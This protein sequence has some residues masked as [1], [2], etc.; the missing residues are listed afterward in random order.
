[1]LICV[2]LPCESYQG[3]LTKFSDGLKTDFYC[4]ENVSCETM[5]SQISDISKEQNVLVYNVQTNPRTMFYSEVNIYADKPA[6]II[7]K[8]TT[9]YMKGYFSSLFSGRTS[10][11][12][13]PFF[14]YSERSI[15][16]WGEFF[17]CRHKRKCK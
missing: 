17:Y 7:L 9:M 2:F 10:V 8:S 3:Y 13:F 14:K 12:F 4:P 15:K 5:L 11:K 16:G 1:M 6:K